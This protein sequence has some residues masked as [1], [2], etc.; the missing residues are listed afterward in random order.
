MKMMML[1]LTIPAPPNMVHTVIPVAE[2]VQT[3]SS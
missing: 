2:I 1:W 3:M